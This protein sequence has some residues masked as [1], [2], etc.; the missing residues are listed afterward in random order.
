M[1]GLSNI[2]KNIMTEEARYNTSTNCYIS[3]SYIK[4]IWGHYYLPLENLL[5]TLNLSGLTT[6]IDM[7]SKRNL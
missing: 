7:P 3:E 5:L 6:H 4:I 2:S 1:S